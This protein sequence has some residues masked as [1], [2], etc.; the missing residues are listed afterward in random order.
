MSDT[1]RHFHKIQPHAGPAIFFQ[2]AAAVLFISES[3]EKE[4]TDESKLYSEQ[5]RAASSDAFARIFQGSGSDRDNKISEVRN[6]IAARLAFTLK[7]GVQPMGEFKD[8]HDIT[9]EHISVKAKKLKEKSEEKGKEISRLMSFAE[10]FPLVSSSI[11]FDIETQSRRQ[12][13][14]DADGRMPNDTGTTFVN[15]LINEEYLDNRT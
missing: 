4:R 1:L 10:E 15:R 3:G 8:K 7:G 5:C 6:Q 2:K 12:S 11:A 13:T 14:S 9:M